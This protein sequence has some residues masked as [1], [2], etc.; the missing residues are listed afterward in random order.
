[1]SSIEPCCICGEHNTLYAGSGYSLYQCI[2]CDYV[3]GTNISGWYFDVEGEHFDIHIHLTQEE[4]EKAWTL[5]REAKAKARK[6]HGHYRW[7]EMGF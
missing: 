4:R 1:M 2:L 7:Q 3:A 5:F 6:K